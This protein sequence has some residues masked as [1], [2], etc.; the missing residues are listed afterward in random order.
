[1]SRLPRTSPVT[2]TGFV[3]FVLLAGLLSAIVLML[4]RQAVHSNRQ[5]VATQLQ[6][7]ARLAA[8][9][10]RTFADDL[11]T[12]AGRIASSVALQ[13][14]LVDGDEVALRRIAASDHAR[15]EFRG[16]A[17]GVL[18]APPRLAS[19]ATIRS[20]SATVARITVGL[21]VDATALARLRHATPLPAKAR[22]LLLEHARVLAGATPGARAAVRSGRLALGGVSYVFGSAPLPV[23]GV[24]VLAIE[25]TADVSA[26]TGTFLRRTLVAAL[27]TLLLAGALAVRLARPLARMFG[28]LSERAERDELTGLAN[29]RTLDD[30]LREEIDRARRYRTHMTLVLVDIDD[31]KQVNDRYGHQCGDD[32]LRRVAVVLSRSLRELDLAGRFGGEEFALVLPGTSVGGA[33]RVAEQIRRAVAQ[34][35]VL[36]PASQ[37]VRITA[38]F[39]MAEFPACAT[40]EDLVERADGCLYDAK[41]RGKNR[42]VA[43]EMSEAERVRLL[44]GVA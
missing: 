44:S 10:A 41:R 5:Q 33:C 25:S 30:R 2:R 14:A 6:G 11:L 29:R 36:G 13:R 26:S 23:K 27:L 40:L 35:D 18:P 1:M 17:F 39:G 22:L 7:S 8:S 12:R 42:V 31:F 16:E 28:D 34:I 38:S 37:R 4:N 9:N 20:G 32:V 19:T 24:R 15:V 21:A 43:P 3:L